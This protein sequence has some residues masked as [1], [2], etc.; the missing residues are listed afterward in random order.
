M[1]RNGVQWCS[2]ENI[3]AKTSQ[4]S[5][6]LSGSSGDVMRSDLRGDL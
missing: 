2:S 4:A 6:G 1:L 3:E 5:F